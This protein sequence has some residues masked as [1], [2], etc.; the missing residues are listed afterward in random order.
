M[1]YSIPEK[2]LDYDTDWKG[3]VPKCSLPRKTLWNNGFGAPIFLSALSQAIRRTPRDTP[4]PF[5]TRTSPSP[6]LLPNL[7]L[8]SEGLLQQC[9]SL[10]I[11]EPKALNWRK[12]FSP[13]PWMWGP[14]GFAHIWPGAH[15]GGHAITRLLRRVLRRVLDIAFEKVPRRV[16]RLRRCLAVGFTGRKVL[17]RGSKKGRSQKALRRKT[18]LFKSIKR[19]Q[20]VYPETHKERHPEKPWKLPESTLNF[21]TFSRFSPMPFVGMPFAPFQEYEPPF[22]VCPTVS[23]C[24]LQPK[25][26]CLQVVTSSALAGTRLALYMLTEAVSVWTIAPSSQ[27]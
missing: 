7:D 11:A 16:L 22:R 3:W 27:K 1:A 24:P 13:N 12:S 9:W 4:A 23:S 17:R 21:M 14:S 18:H 2:G 25:L 26:F 6:I 20:T 5:Y 19:V 10:Q 8:F 15:Q